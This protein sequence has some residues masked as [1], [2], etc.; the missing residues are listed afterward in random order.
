[1][2]EPLVRP[3]RVLRRDADGELVVYDFHL[4]IEVKAAP[5]DEQRLQALVE[6]RLRQFAAQLKN[7]AR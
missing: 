4:E 1:M 6:E 5:A 2:T 3:Q 7:S